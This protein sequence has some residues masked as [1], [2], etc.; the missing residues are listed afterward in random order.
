M[1]LEDPLE[2]PDGALTTPRLDDGAQKGFAL[3]QSLLASG[4]GGGGRQQQLQ[5]PGTTLALSKAELSKENAAS[6]S[7]LSELNELN[8]G[9]ESRSDRASK[10]SQSVARNVMPYS[11]VEEQEAF[12]RELEID[13][14][15]RAAVWEAL[16]VVLE[17]LVGRRLGERHLVLYRSAVIDAAT[18]RQ[19]FV[20]DADRLIQWLSAAVLEGSELATRVKVMPAPSEEVSYDYNNGGFRYRHQ[21]A[22]PFDSLASVLTLAPLPEAGGVSFVYL[23]R[24][25]VAHGD[26]GPR[27]PLSYG[28]GTAR[29]CRAASELRLRCLPRAQNSAD[30]DP[31][32]RGDAPRR[33]C[34]R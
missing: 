9:A 32:V 5:V 6:D 29:L 3:V 4:F 23:L 21:F 31:H 19:G 18:Y 14:K 11:E 8:R 26:G 15:S 10:I 28:H 17:S 1:D 27:W 22:E 16:D 25:N 2:S 7:Y 34:F 30:G 24:A 12:R 20:V 13:E 33:T